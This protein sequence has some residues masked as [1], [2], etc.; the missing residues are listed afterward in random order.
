LIKVIWHEGQG[1]CQFSKKLELRRTLPLDLKACLRVV[2]F[3]GAERPNHDAD[4]TGAAL[5]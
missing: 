3:L 1:A 4:R 2:R 5:T